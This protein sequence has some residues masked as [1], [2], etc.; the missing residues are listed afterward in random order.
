MYV[1][2]WHVI[3]LG[4]TG[5]HVRHRWRAQQKKREKKRRMKSES[6]NGRCVRMCL[7][8]TAGLQRATINIEVQSKNLLSIEYISACKMPFVI[9]LIKS[10]R[11]LYVRVR[12]PF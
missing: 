12:V 8:S 7:T 5:T 6:N 2:A 3:F 11:Y 10:S 9:P 1:F 4:P